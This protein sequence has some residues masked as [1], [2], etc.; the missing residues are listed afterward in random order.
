[1]AIASCYPPSIFT[2]QV[3][4]SFYGYQRYRKEKV[5]K[6]CE[7]DSIEITVSPI[8]PSSEVFFFFS[9]RSICVDGIVF[10]AYTDHFGPHSKFSI[11]V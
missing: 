2:S 4:N 9:K 6:E 11:S 7:D 1:M 10:T 8:N 5:P 3:L